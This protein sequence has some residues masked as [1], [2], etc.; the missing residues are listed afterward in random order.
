MH[1]HLPAAQV[2]PWLM[3]AKT[4]LSMTLLFMLQASNESLQLLTHQKTGFVVIE[5]TSFLQD[6][7][8]QKTT[9]DDNQKQA[10][11]AQ[12]N[13]I[14]RTNTSSQ[15]CLNAQ[16]LTR[17]G[18]RAHVPIRRTYS[19]SSECKG[20]CQSIARIESFLQEPTLAPSLTYRR[21]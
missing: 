3:H 14:A 5:T 6:E 1:T 19:S 18:P 16:E 4:Q 10:R 11:R 21:G 7:D 20:L 9:Y 15:T 13:A 2:F 17:R 8:Y 12:V